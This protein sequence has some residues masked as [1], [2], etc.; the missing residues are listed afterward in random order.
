M[1]AEGQMCET[2]AAV[3]Q[4]NRRR[5]LTDLLGPAAVAAIS[6]GAVSASWPAQAQSSDAVKAIDT[7][8]SASAKWFADAYDAGHRLYIPSTTDVDHGS[9]SKMPWG[10]ASA[11][12]RLALDTGMMVGAYSRDPSL[13]QIAI[14]ACRPYVDRLQFFAL[15]IED[16]GSR[17]TRDM[18]NGVRSLGVRPLVYS[19]EH[20]WSDVMGGDVTAFS[21][22]PLWDSSASRDWPIDSPADMSE[23]RPL[24]FGGWNTP[25]NL[26]V[27]VQ[28]GQELYFNG[29][30]VDVSSFNAQFL[31]PG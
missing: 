18:I 21:D 7:T 3:S 22:L 28:Q 30:K 6:G 23:P 27:G 26:R 1:V 9:G 19:G 12:L 16:P 17:L 13:W 8:E 11:Q 2:M 14:E 4:Q 10:Q 5:F 31:V 25:D 20:C 29:R 15:D 24:V